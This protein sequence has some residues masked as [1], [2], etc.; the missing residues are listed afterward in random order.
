MVLLSSFRGRLFLEVWR[1]PTVRVTLLSA[2]TTLWIPR[3]S[4][5]CFISDSLSRPRLS[6]TSSMKRKDRDSV[7]AL[8]QPLRPLPMIPTPFY[9]RSRHGWCCSRIF[10]SPLPGGSTTPHCR[11]DLLMGQH[12][13]LQPEG[14]QWGWFQFYRARVCQGTLQ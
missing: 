7:P 8:S 6:G 4:N 12:K 9:A 3:G 1:P 10:G 2:S 11:C 5:G 13:A 14:L